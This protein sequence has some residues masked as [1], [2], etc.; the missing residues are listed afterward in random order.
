MTPSMACVAKSVRTNSAMPG[1]PLLNITSLATALIVGILTNLLVNGGHLSGD[2]EPSHPLAG[3]V[4]GMENV[5]I[6]E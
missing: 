4:D 5:T 3:H 6:D 2:E 1:S